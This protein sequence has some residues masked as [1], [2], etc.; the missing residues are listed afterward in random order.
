MANSLHQEYS[1]T[2]IDLNTDPQK[3]PGA[4]LHQHPCPWPPV[5]STAQHSSR[6]T[7]FAKLSEPLD[8]PLDF[9]MSAGL[10]AVVTCT[11]CGALTAASGNFCSNCGH[12]RK[13]AYM[14][15]D[16]SP[17]TPRERMPVYC[18]DYPHI[19]VDGAS[20]HGDSMLSS[21]ATM[22]GG[23]PQ[24]VVREKECT[25]RQMEFGSALR[26]PQKVIT[27]LDAAPGSA[28][29][30]PPTT[31]MIR[32]VPGAYTPDMLLEE[33][34]NEGTFDFV[35]LPY[36]TRLQRNLT[37]AFVNF[38]TTGY[39]QDFMNKWQ[40]MRLKHYMAQKPLNIGFADTQGRN[41][42]LR[43]LKKKRLLH[44]KDKK[45]QPLVFKDGRRIL[46]KDALADA[47]AETDE[48]AMPWSIQRLAL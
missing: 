47:L 34:P 36:S 24:R 31:L 12:P 22:L 43:N 10:G 8:V 27:C 35:Y 33:W 42:N 11:R 4:F 44:T 41:E 25:D 1:K 29:P 18:S 28:A 37:Y 9:P 46:L 13:D 45:C 19:S 17:P 2:S 16:S 23:V 7:N 26:T 21:G 3:I 32:N 6:K 40:K 39:A 5:F 14:F 38:T 48:S 30:M 15:E 20:D